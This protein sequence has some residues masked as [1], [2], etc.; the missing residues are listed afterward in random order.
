M[1]SVR[2]SAGLPSISSSFSYILIALSEDL[3]WFV[4]G[5][6]ENVGQYIFIRD[7]KRRVFKI[8]AQRLHLQQDSLNKMISPLATV[9]LSFHDLEITTK[10]LVEA[11]DPVEIFEDSAHDCKRQRVEHTT[12]SS[13]KALNCEVIEKSALDLYYVWRRWQGMAE[14]V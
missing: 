7:E 13:A 14:V 2:R 1:F 6:G 5:A 4:L 8:C 3:C 12:D 9:L 10:R 11:V